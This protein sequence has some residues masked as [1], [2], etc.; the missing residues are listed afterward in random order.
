MAIAYELAFEENDK[1]FRDTVIFL[2]AV[3]EIKRS[4]APITAL[5]VSHDGVFRKRKEQLE[6]WA[7]GAGAS[8]VV[9]A[10]LEE[11]EAALE[12]RQTAQIQAQIEQDRKALETALNQR[13]GDIQDWLEQN[14]ESF[15]WQETLPFFPG[16]APFRIGSVKVGRLISAT[17]QYDPHRNNDERVRFSFDIEARLLGFAVVQ[18]DPGAWQPGGLSAFPYRP[19]LQPFNR[20]LEIDAEATIKG[21]E[22]TDFRFLT[23]R[24]KQPPMPPMPGAT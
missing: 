13:L 5:L 21:H 22:H 7:K 4:P 8:V 14:V 16:M 11:I 15:K 10:T 23:A 17:P 18:I 3:D 1:G 12:H 20:V 24:I 6:S 2:A 9:C 19:S